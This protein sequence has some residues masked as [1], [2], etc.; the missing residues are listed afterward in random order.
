MPSSCRTKR[1]RVE[2][3]EDGYADS[4]PPSSSP[5]AE[6]AAA[7]TDANVAGAAAAAATAAVAAAA[8]AAAG[9]PASPSDCCCCGSRQRI[10]CL[11]A[12]VPEVAPSA[13][14]AS[15][16][17]SGGRVVGRPPTSTGVSLG[18][19]RSTRSRGPT[20]LDDCRTPEGGKAGCSRKFW[21]RSS[22]V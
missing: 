16:A 2:I 22:A 15:T 11:A 9:V 8:A 20:E 17:A 12:T 6:D 10:R 18:A 13:P 7:D 3:E 4:L 5:P 21:I 19:R 14:V 1:G